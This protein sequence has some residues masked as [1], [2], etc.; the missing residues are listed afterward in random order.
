MGPLILAFDTSSEFASLALVRGSEILDDVLLHS[1]DGFAHLLFGEVDRLLK[2]NGVAI[3]DIACFAAGSGPGSFTGIR[4]ALS[5]AKG[6]AEACGKPVAAVSNLQ[7]LAWHGS[8]NR[9]A[10]LLDA[11][12]GEVYG[13]LYDGA[14]QLVMPETVAPFAAWLPTLPADVEFV[15]V[16]PS[17]FPVPQDRATIAPRGMARAIAAVAFDRLAAGDVMDPAAV[18]ANYVRRS[19]AELHWREA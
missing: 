5:A 13:A 19:D 8:T 15:C 12:R 3:T 1:P 16:D 4:V 18:D 6:L 9:R 10:P 2:R 11:R 14:L 17:P 7:A